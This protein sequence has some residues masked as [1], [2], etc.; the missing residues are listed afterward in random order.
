MIDREIAIEDIKSKVDAMLNILENIINDWVL[1]FNLTNLEELKS[2]N[3]IINFDQF[4]KNLINNN[5]EN[6]LVRPRFN[7]T[8]PLNK[9]HPYKVTNMESIHENID[10]ILNLYGG[11]ISPESTALLDDIYNTTYKLKDPEYKKNN[12][13]F[14][15]DLK[16]IYDKL[17]K[18]QF[19]LTSKL[20]Y[21]VEYVF[22]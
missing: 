1:I 12:L 15:K 19:K 14:M 5:D 13:I 21:S 20:N 10:E 22:Y 2:G 17:K 8:L 11:F 18:I 9:D 6:Y 16:S 3:F 4:K 7:E